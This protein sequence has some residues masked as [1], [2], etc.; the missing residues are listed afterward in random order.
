MIY[1]LAIGADPPRYGPRVQLGASRFPRLCEDG[2]EIRDDV[3][4]SALERE[5]LDW[6]AAR[7]DLEL[8]NVTPCPRARRPPSARAGAGFLHA[9]NNGRSAMS[10][11]ENKRVFVASARRATGVPLSSRGKCATIH[12]H[13]PRRVTRVTSWPALR[14]GA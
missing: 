13:K 2:R 3:Q 4:L 6:F 14:S 1:L 12:D 11:A 8:G 5:E 10:A 9:V 7:E